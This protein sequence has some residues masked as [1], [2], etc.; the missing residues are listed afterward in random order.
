MKK[1]KRIV[2]LFL[3]LSMTFGIMPAFGAASGAGWRIDYD[4]A[5]YEPGSLRV[6]IYDAARRS[7]PRL[8]WIDDGETLR[9]DRVPDGLFAS[10]GD[11][12]AVVQYTKGQ[13][14]GAG[15]ASGLSDAEIDREF[16][17]Y[18]SAV[19]GKPVPSLPAP[20]AKPATTSPSVTVRRRLSEI[21]ADG[22]PRAPDPGRIAE[23]RPFSAI[24]TDPRRVV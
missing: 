22:G 17:L 7:S 24:D 13:S 1:I 21:P 14:G 16:D 18:Y 23:K 19:Y 8:Y 3:L 2:S 12:Y 9:P 15:T 10:G 4:T 20:P 6:E 5:E 11:Y